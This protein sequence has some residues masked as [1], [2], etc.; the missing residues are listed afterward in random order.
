MN[1]GILGMIIGTALGIG[2]YTV[3]FWLHSKIDWS[4]YDE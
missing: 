2:V 3:M 4:Y 1:E